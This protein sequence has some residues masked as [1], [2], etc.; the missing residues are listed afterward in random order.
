MWI[1]RIHTVLWGISAGQKQTDKRGSANSNFSLGKCYVVFSRA[2][3]EWL[4]TLKT[5]KIE[6]CTEERNAGFTVNDA[7]VTC[8]VSIW[9]QNET[10]QNAK[11]DKEWG[12][13]Q[14]FF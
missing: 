8:S 9:C 5:A 11:G 14:I 13:T 2:K 12:R 1:S 3:F 10:K 6:H 7:P 4:L